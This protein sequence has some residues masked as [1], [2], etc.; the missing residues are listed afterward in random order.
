MKPTIK[1]DYSEFSVWCEKYIIA[2]LERWKQEYLEYKAS[3]GYIARPYAKA[4]KC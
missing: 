4:N 3:L 2:T 1:F